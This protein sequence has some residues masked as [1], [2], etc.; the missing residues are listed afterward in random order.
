[1]CRE[2]KQGTAEMM[3][4]PRSAAHMGVNGKVDPTSDA[5]WTTADDCDE[6]C[7]DS[8]MDLERTQV[9]SGAST[10]N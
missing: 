2:R 3:E 10:T 1:M 4:E 6:A 7:R 8:K 5:H 9:H